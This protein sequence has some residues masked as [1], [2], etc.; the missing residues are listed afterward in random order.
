MKTYMK[1]M[2]PSHLNAASKLT[3]S[4]SEYQTLTEDKPH[5]PSSPVT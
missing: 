5:H 1:K 2:N 4:S 3:V